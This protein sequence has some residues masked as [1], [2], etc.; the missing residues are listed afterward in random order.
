MERCGLERKGS[1]RVEGGGELVCVFFFGRREARWTSWVC[2]WV[3]CINM[4]FVTKKK[5]EVLNVFS[6]FCFWRLLR[7]LLV[8]VGIPCSV[9]VVINSLLF[10]ACERVLFPRVNLVG[11]VLTSLTMSARPQGTSCEQ[12]S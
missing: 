3:K 12:H 6:H 2:L 4:L 8:S 7:V 10:L 5:E 9:P 1:G 11:Q